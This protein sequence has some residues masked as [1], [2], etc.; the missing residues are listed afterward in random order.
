MV[1]ECAIRESKTLNFFKLNPPSHKKRCS[2]SGV[3]CRDRHRGNAGRGTGGTERNGSGLEDSKPYRFRIRPVFK[4]PSDGDGQEAAKEK[5]WGWSP[6]STPASPAVLNSFLSSSVPQQLVRRGKEVV[7]RDV[8]AG[9]VV[10]ERRVNALFYTSSPIFHGNE[11]VILRVVSR[12]TCKSVPF[13]GI[14]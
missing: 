4:P 3:T 6:A 10:G 5:R 1:C 14:A 2:L 13:L 8:L 9:K 11:L 7:S 12:G